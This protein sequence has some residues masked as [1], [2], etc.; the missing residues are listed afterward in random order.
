MAAARTPL[1]ARRAGLLA[2]AALAIA[3][4]AAP[5]P[6]RADCVVTAPIRDLMRLAACGNPQ[7][8]FTATP[9][10]AL[11]GQ[12]IAFDATS[13]FDPNPG[14]VIADY[15]WDLDGNGTYE[16]DTGT[17]P[18]VQTSFA[19][20]GRYTVGLEVTN[21]TGQTGATSV[22]VSVTTPPVADFTVAPTS[23]LT[24]QTTTLDGSTSSDP[25][26]LPIAKYEWDLDG[27]GTYETDTGTTA[28]TTTSFAT[29]GNH[30]VSLRVT[31]ADGATATKTVT[32]AAQNRPP[33]AS[34]TGPAPAIVGSTAS[35]D[36]SAS[37]DPDG[38]IAT[39][40]WDL[41]GDG[42]YETSTGTDPHASTTYAAAGVVT[43]GLRVTDDL[44]ATSTT[45]LTVHVTHAPV[46]SF[47]AAPNPVSLHVP[48]S[49]DAS[50]SSDADGPIARYEWD[51]DGNGTYETDTGTTPTTSHVYT[52]NGTYAV[53]LR[54]TDAD[55]ATATTTVNLVAANQPPVAVLVATPN[56]S[57]VDQPVGLDASASSDTDGTIVRYDWDLDGNGSFETP[58]GSSPTLSHAYPNPGAYDVGVRV[59]DNDGGV[60]V[61]RVHLVVGLPP[62]GGGGAGGA[63]AS[64]AGAGTG[65]GATPSGGSTLSGG[66]TSGDGA[67]TGASL[68]ARLTGLPIQRV[69][70]VLSG[71]LAVGCDADRA[72]SCRLSASLPARE[73]RRLG[74]RSRRPVTLG[75]VVIVLRGAGA[76]TARLRL[77][78]AG[79]RAV[80]RARSATVLVA[81][82]AVDATGRRLILVRT[83]LL[84]R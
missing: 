54:V 42:T 12:T 47:T 28:T 38:T 60:G 16:T 51:L 50:A 80:R 15:K 4:T 78:A 11:P 68:S 79:R 66:S 10:P 48:V 35:F 65:S 39:Y 46:A 40:E 52:A 61:A 18:T 59:T 26:G 22:Q 83:F 29:P 62:A 45:T 21:G 58:G 32:I 70:S 72:V 73:A 55:G 34:F 71:G 33:V 5:A 74:M 1:G 2:L 13:S 84:R 77:S 24:G 6:A 31:D 57:V 44:G 17:T 43:V 53:G 8:N 49:F 41:D 69:S 64:G 67:G 56:Q 3:C 36:A 19:T 14:G 27:D 20:R 82:T 81:G 63:E 7:A 76:G 30:N 25:D 75:S 9:N 37:S 23:P